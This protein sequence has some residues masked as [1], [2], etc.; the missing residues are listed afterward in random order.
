MQSHPN[1]PPY[2]LRAIDRVMADP[3]RFST[4][5]TSRDALDTLLHEI[6]LEAPGDGSGTRSAG[7]R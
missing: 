1:L 5:R 7:T 2:L 4:I 6:R 3:D